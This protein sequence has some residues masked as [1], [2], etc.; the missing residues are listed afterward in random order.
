V[1]LGG[2]SVIDHPRGADS[3]PL[4]L[5]VHGTMDRSASF[6][7]T[8]RRLTDVDSRGYDRRGYAGSLGLGASSEIARHVADAQ[9]V[10]TGR[11]SVVI[12]HSFGGLVALALAAEEPE[13][14]AGVGVY[15]PPVSWIPGLTRARPIV[16]LDAPPRE[17]A[18]AFFRRTVGERTWTRMPETV[19]E[20]RRAEGEAII[21]DLRMAARGP[22]VELENVGQEVHIA[23]GDDPARHYAVGARR[24]ADL[25]P[26]TRLRHFEGVGH[27]AHLSHPDRFADWIAGIDALRLG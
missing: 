3:L 26:R 10:L 13:L 5:L 1:R 9:A 7:R 8:L 16:D 11:R 12:G 20:A 24:L 6:R 25:L 27:G 22:G 4:V 18:E 2:L 17:V 19:R 23:H 14:V 21:A 15:E